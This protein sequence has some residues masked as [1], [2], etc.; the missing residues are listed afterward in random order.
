MS[1]LIKGSICSV[2]HNKQN[3]YA[4][5][6]GNKAT[7]LIMSEEFYIVLS[8]EL[9]ELSAQKAA[10]KIEDSFSGVPIIKTKVRDVIK[11]Y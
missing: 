9:D 4:A 2:L 8:E 10:E 7:V 6:Y 1:H 11:F 3:A 5:M